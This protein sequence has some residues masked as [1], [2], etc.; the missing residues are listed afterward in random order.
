MLNFI[1]RKIALVWAKKHVKQTE[2]FKRFVVID[3]RTDLS[4]TE[5]K[6]IESRRRKKQRKIFILS[7]GKT[8]DKRI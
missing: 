4:E 5:S 2:N 6:T 8:M 7:N 1:K 3:D